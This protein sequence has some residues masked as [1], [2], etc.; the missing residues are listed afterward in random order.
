MFSI[1]FRRVLEEKNKL[2]RQKKMEP[3]IEQAKLDAKKFRNRVIDLIDSPQNQNEINK[4]NVGIYY[5]NEIASRSESVCAEYAKHVE[6]SLRDQGFTNFKI[7]S[8]Y[9]EFENR[10]CCR[11]AVEPL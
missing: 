4:L 7:R 2:V 10:T 1:D 6:R 11:V 8:R 5:D 3:L 9:S